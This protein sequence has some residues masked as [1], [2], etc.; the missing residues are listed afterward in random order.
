MKNF[1][2]IAMAMIFGFVL[3]NAQD[4]EANEPDIRIH[5]EKQYDDDG[6]VIGVDSTYSLSWSSADMPMNVDSLFESLGFGGNSQFYFNFPNPNEWMRDFNFDGFDHDQRF[7]HIDS[8]FSNGTFN[9]DFFQGEEMK[10]LM[11]NMNKMLHQNMQQFHQLF[12]DDAFEFFR[13]DPNTGDSLNLLR[14]T[15][16]KLK[17]GQKRI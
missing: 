10:D 16:P 15:H 4:K 2:S 3:V 12:N 8:L 5:V 6:N 14:P 13:I 1:L 17:P 7:E 9:F 11:E